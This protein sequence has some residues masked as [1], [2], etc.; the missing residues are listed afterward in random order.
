MCP[1]AAK[2]RIAPLQDEEDLNILFDKNV[3]TNVAARVPPTSGSRINIDDDGEGSGCEGEEGP[4][5]TPLHTR[6]KKKRACPYS[7]TPT[8]TSKMSIG[9]SSASRLDRMMEMMEQREINKERIRMMEEEKSKN[10]VTSPERVQESSR[11]EI[12][13]L[14]ALIY[15]DGA[16]PG[17][18]EYF[19]AT[20][21]FLLQEYR[22]M[23]ACLVEDA[24]PAQRLDWIRMTWEQYSKK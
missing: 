4:V 10:S 24:T 11:D 22:E 19:Y 1:E 16:T 12:R 20:Q 21:L 9:S 6:G 23:F 8:G 17:S 18:P 14:V 7:P 15:Q 13:R 5:L 3:V 2:F